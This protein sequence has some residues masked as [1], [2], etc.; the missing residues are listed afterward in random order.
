MWDLLSRLASVKIAAVEC[1]SGENQSSV[2]RVR[3]YK[4]KRKKRR[5]I[6]MRFYSCGLI[7]CHCW[8]CHV[9]LRDKGTRATRDSYEINCR[10][11]GCIFAGQSRRCILDGKKSRWRSSFVKEKKKKRKTSAWVIACFSKIVNFKCKICK[12]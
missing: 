6:N 8:D 4:A 7:Y 5:A 11:P 12:R 1:K 9:C 3:I 10:S 2:T